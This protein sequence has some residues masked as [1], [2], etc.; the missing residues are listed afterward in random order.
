MTSA[1]ITSKPFEDDDASLYS[2]EYCVYIEIFEKQL[3]EWPDITW[4]DSFYT[5]DFPR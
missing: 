2:K 1:L 3:P 4:V 5:N